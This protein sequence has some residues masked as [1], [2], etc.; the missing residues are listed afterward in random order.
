MIE[1]D[2]LDPPNWQDP[3]PTYA[4]LRNEAPVHFAEQTGTYCISRY[5]DVAR[6]MRDHATFSSTGAFEILIK[7]RMA[8]FGMRN[9]LEIAR[10]L[11][12]V[13]LR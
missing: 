12:R 11:Y 10:F 13:P 4:R 6:V 8:S 1:Y 3:Y 7:D 9:A 5:A 2:P